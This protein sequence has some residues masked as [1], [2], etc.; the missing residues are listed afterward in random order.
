MSIQVILPAKIVIDVRPFKIDLAQYLQG[1]ETITAVDPSVTVFTGG[2]ANPGDLLYLS[3]EIDGTVVWQRIKSGIPGN[4][5][6]VTLSVTTSLGN[7]IEACAVQA[8]LPDGVPAED[9][10]VPLYLTSWVYPLEAEDFLDSHGSI[11]G[12]FTLKVTEDYLDSSALILSGSLFGSLESY[13]NPAEAVDSSVAFL[14]GT[15]EDI[16]QEYSIPAEAVDSAAAIISGTLYGELITYSNYAPEGV[17]SSA[18][19]LSG[20][21]T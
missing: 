7:V 16:L 8:V 10:Y 3:P 19:I 15:L 11:V 2:D 1:G 14:S 9:L 5:Y 20:S 4:I 13:S 18:I 12:G 17:D 21:L 6:T